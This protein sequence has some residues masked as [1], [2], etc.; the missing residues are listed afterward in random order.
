MAKLGAWTAWG[1]VEMRRKKVVPAIWITKL[2][3][4]QFTHAIK[5]CC[6]VSGM[7]WRW[8]SS[9]TRTLSLW[10]HW[11]PR[12]SCRRMLD[13]SQNVI[14]PNIWSSDVMKEPVLLFKRW[15]QKSTGSEVLQNPLN[16]NLECTLLTFINRRSSWA[17]M[18]YGPSRQNEWGRQTLN[19]RRWSL[20]SA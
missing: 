19:D 5:L 4:E 17:D 14:D 3:R 6:G 13:A 1:Q 16:S 18:R 20:L 8:H 9:V 11:S 2:G 15:Q 10:R 12:V 7:P